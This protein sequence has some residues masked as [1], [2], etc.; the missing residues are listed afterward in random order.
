[1]FF[2]ITL[3][4]TGLLVVG[5]FFFWQFMILSSLTKSKKR[6]HGDIASPEEEI[7]SKLTDKFDDEPA[8]SEPSDNDVLTPPRKQYLEAL[9][10]AKLNDFSA[11]EIILE[12]AIIVAQQENDQQ[13]IC[14]IRLLLAD[15]SRRSGDMT[16]ACEHWQ[17]A[18]EI[19][20]KNGD[21]RRARNIEKIMSEAGCP[22]DWVLNEF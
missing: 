11:A 12:K 7:D 9:G 8:W 21:V 3:F 16:S 20:E 1:M 17:M 2:F 6:Q 14:D 22:T 10:L 19:Y 5:L 4:F 13:T 15:I 18:R